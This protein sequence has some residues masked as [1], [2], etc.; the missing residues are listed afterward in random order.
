[1]QGEL[2]GVSP[3]IVQQCEAH[4]AVA[5]GGTGLECG[6]LLSGG[7]GEISDAGVCCAELFIFRQHIW[8]SGGVREQ[9]SECDG[10]ERSAAKVGA[11]CSQVFVEPEPALCGELY[12]Q[13]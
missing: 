9:M 2:S 6:I 10:A 11:E 4:A 12:G 3:S 5:D 1:M 8:E 7:G 13:Q